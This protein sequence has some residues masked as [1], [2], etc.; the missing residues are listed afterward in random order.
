MHA[1]GISWGRTSLSL[2]LVAAGGGFQCLRTPMDAPG[3]DIPALATGLS[4]CWN[5]Q[6]VVRNPVGI[7]PWN[8]KGVEWGASVTAQAWDATRHPW[9]IG[10]CRTDPARLQGAFPWIYSTGQMCVKPIL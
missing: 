8:T 6:L 1:S 4:L 3:M 7:R 9:G 2:V 10:S 5:Q